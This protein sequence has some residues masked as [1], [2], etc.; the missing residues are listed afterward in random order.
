MPKSYVPRSVIKTY[1][2]V[3]DQVNK[4]LGRS[5][6]IYMRGDHDPDIV[7]DSGANCP[8]NPQDY[9][10]EDEWWEWTT[11]TINNVS[12]IW[13]DEMSQFFPAGRFEPHECELT[14]NLSTVLI[15][16][17]DV[18]SDTYFDT[19]AYCIVDGKKCVKNSVVTKMGLKDLYM[20][21]VTVTSKLTD[22]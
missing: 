9:P 11:H 14:V 6:T 20:C 3:M 5:I 18:N 12:T 19:M 1:Q 7:W 21:K 2:E 17:S 16:P 4:D 10:D 13:G 8:V 22:D 15:D